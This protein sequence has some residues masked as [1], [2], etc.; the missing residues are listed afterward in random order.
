MELPEFTGTD[1]IRWNS[2][3]GN[4]FKDEEIPLFHTWAFMSMEGAAIFWFHSWCQE[5]PNPDCESFSTAA[6]RRFEKGGDANNIEGLAI[7]E[8]GTNVQAL[9]EMKRNEENL[10]GNGFEGQTDGIHSQ[11][12]K[13]S[14]KT[15]G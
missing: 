7:E 15:W 2:K 13:Q 5:N 1:P 11:Q 10:N 12:T 4:F 3:A 6:T 9:G 14:K 8:D